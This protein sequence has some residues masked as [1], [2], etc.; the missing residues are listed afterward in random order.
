MKRINRKSTLMSGKEVFLKNEKSRFTKEEDKIL[1]SLISSQENPNW[2]LISKKMKNRTVRQCR[3]RWN[4]YLNPELKS[5]KWTTNED[6]IL[7]KKLEEIGPFWHRISLFIK[8]RTPNSIRNRYLVLRRRNIVREYKKIDCA[9]NS[10]DIICSNN[11]SGG[12]LVNSDNQCTASSDDN[13]SPDMTDSERREFLD[14]LFI[15]D[16][17]DFDILGED[18]Y[19]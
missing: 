15:G 16:I 11:S 4:H 18:V 7:I 3:D 10:D 8:G 17:F 14:S 12:F 2:N 5:G 9:N 1:I 6:R 13:K 19:F